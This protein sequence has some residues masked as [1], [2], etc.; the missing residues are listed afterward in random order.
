MKVQI[1]ADASTRDVLCI[2]VGKGSQHDFKG[3]ADL[4]HEAPLWNPSLPVLRKE[5]A[6]AAAIRI[7]AWGIGGEAPML[8]FR[9]ALE[10]F[11][12]RCFAYFF[13]AKYA[14]LF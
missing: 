12:Y 6:G 11:A 13:L 9:E 3:S 1:V 10:I 4:I 8:I 2:S 5:L 14:F 7:A